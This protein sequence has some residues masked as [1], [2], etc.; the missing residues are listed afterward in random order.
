MSPS[1]KVWRFG[2]CLGGSGLSLGLFKVL[3]LGRLEPKLG[4][5]VIL[6]IFDFV[7][8]PNDD[9]SVFMYWKSPNC[10]IHSS[11]SFVPSLTWYL[12]FGCCF[13]FSLQFFS[14]DFIVGNN[15]WEGGGHY[16]RQKYFCGNSKHY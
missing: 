16:H 4:R 3:P 13:F 6:S 5:V 10:L 12:R 11:T 8:G 2:V 9:G 14:I 15:S 7:K 1:V